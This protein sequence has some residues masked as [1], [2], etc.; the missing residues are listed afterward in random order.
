MSGSGAERSAALAFIVKNTRL[1]CL[2]W[3]RSSEDENADNAQG[4]AKIGLLT[5]YK[6]TTIFCR[7]GP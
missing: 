6:R 7:C 2:N 1:F 4:Y 5:G 3:A